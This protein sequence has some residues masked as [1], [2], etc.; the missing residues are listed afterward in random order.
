VKILSRYPFSDRPSTVSFQ[1][2]VEEVKPFQIVVWVGIATRNGV[3]RMLPAFLD[4]GHNETFSIAEGKLRAW[5]GIDYRALRLLPGVRIGKH[6]LPRCDADL[7]IYR[8]VPGRNAI[9]TNRPFRLSLPSGIIIQHP[10]TATRLP[11]LGMRGLVENKLKLQ[12]DGR[13]REVTLTTGY[14]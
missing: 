10:D 12:I 11:I 5:A 7:V 14:W 1:Q 13:R 9:S 2:V 8:N 6:L 4:S 3:S